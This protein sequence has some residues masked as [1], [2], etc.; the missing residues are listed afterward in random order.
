MNSFPNSVWCPSLWIRCWKGELK[1]I[2]HLQITLTYSLCLIV[3]RLG[4]VPS[5][6]ALMT[7]R[8]RRFGTKLCSH[9]RLRD[10]WDCIGDA[11]FLKFEHSIWTKSSTSCLFEMMH[12]QG[13]KSSYWVD[14]LKSQMMHSGRQSLCILFIQSHIC[15]S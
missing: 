15:I 9:L 3:N 14:C 7:V 12:F 1:G 13:L 5:S 10:V 6:S 11:R 2:A 8:A 4:Y